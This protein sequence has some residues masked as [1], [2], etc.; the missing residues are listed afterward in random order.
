[1]NV[2]AANVV[3]QLAESWD[4]DDGGGINLDPEHCA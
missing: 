4:D 1:V 2:N 3:D